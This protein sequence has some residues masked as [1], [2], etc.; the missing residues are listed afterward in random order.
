MHTHKRIGC[1]LVSI[2]LILCCC[3]CGKSEKIVTSANSSGSTI[4]AKSS[5]ADSDSHAGLRSHTPTVLIPSADGTVTYGNDIA[6]IDASHTSEGYVMVSYL[7]TNEKVK[8]QITGSDAV[9]YTY[10]LHGGYESFPLTSGNG[11]YTLNIYENLS[12]DQ[13]STALSQTLDVT[14]TN[15]FGPYLYPNQYVYFTEDMDVVDESSRLAEDADSDLDVVDSVYN[16]IISEF[17]YDYDK[18]SSVQS[19]YLPVIDDT[20]AAKSGICFDYAAAMTSLLRIQGIPTRLEIG[21]MD[22]VYHAWLSTYIEGSGWINGVIE[23]NGNGWEMMDP[24]FAST[25]NSPKKFTMENEKYTI[26]YVY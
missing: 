18:A 7:G 11:S 14:I 26:Q 19:G 10:N 5:T 4:S 1:F 25:S 8:L 22:D 13:Y 16:Y 20:L 6:S 21:Y 15:E 3:S 24:T 12:G 17:S 2:L 23:F 9:T